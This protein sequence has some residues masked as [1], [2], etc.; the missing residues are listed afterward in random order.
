MVLAASFVSLGI[1]FAG[2]R[3]LFLFLKKFENKKQ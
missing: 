2:I 3:F 1:M